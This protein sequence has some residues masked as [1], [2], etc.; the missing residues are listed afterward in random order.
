M[1]EF[2]PFSLQTNSKLSQRT[3]PTNKMSSD[4][5]MHMHESENLNEVEEEKKELLSDSED[6]IITPQYQMDLSE[7]SKHKL[8]WKL[9]GVKQFSE[10]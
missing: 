4:Y 3:K 10:C 1:L 9:W 8:H 5:E 7:H 6:G 2:F